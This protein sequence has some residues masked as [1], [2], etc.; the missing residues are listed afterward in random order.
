L[1]NNKRLMAHSL[2]GTP[3]YIAPEI[4]SRKGYTKLCDWWSVGV[5]FYE[6]IM[7]YTPFRGE[8]TLETQFNVS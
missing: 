8:S 6:M 5:I 1:D 3:D 4:L 7:G 2:V